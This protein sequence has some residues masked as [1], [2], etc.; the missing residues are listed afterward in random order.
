MATAIAA[1]STGVLCPGYISPQSQD[2]EGRGEAGRGLLD[3][4]DENLSEGLWGPT[5]MFLERIRS[6]A[7]ATFEHIDL[8]LFLAPQMYRFSRAALWIG[9]TSFLIPFLPAAMAETFKAYTGL[10]GGMPGI[11]PTSWKVPDCYH[12]FWPAGSTL[13]FSYV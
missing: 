9:A 13:K 4:P 8:P 6:A 3:E 7:G 2:G 10:S 11:F 12:G 1:A 5:E